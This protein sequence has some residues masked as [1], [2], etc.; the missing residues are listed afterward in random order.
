[1]LEPAAGLAGRQV[2]RRTANA[3]SQPWPDVQ[4]RIVAEVRGLFAWAAALDTYL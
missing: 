2:A 3:A 1:M 4:A